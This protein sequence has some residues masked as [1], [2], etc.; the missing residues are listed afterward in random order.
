MEKKIQKEVN[1]IKRVAIFIDEVNFESSAIELGMYVDL[2]K[3]KDYLVG[4]N[5]LYNCFYYATGSHEDYHTSSKSG[6]YH[7][8]TINGFTIK[9]KPV[10]KIPDPKDHN[11]I[12]GEKCNIDVELTLDVV[13]TVNNYD[14]AVLITGDSDFCKI[15]EF[16]RYSGK[17]VYAVSTGEPSSIDLK[18]IV[19]KYIDLKEIK[20]KI[21]YK[22][23]Y[24]K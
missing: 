2:V 22:K 5:E 4:K 9:M 15:V 17:E 8:L 21:K 11:K 13:T 1:K 14:I 20:N 19:D 24:K 18:N 12:I 10:K 6:F 16:L 3:L 23:P 7:R